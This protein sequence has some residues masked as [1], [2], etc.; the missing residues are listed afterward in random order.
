MESALYDAAGRLLRARRPPRRARRVHDRPDRRP[1]LRPR[2]GRRPARPLGAARAPGALHDRRG[3]PR[4]RLARGGSG[5]RRWRTC[6][7]TS[8]CAS[9]PRA[10]SRRPGHACRGRASLELAQLEGVPR[11]DRR[12]RGAR[13]LPGPPPALARRAARRRRRRRPLR[14]RAR[15]RRRAPSASRCGPPASR[16]A[17]APSTTS[18]PPRPSCSGRSPARSHAER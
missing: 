3:R 16:R 12:Q 10:C 5:R 17:T 8:C 14:V 1:V 7:S 2:A 4:R 18:S 9:A 15:A 6:R 11:G 13:R